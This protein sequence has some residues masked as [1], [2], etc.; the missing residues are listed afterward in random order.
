MHWSK[1][2]LAKKKVDKNNEN[3]CLII[4]KGFKSF[5]GETY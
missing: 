4:R 1:A 2:I 5:K 3:K